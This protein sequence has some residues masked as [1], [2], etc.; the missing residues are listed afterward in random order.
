MR[1]AHD[2]GR[3]P[4]PFSVKPMFSFF[5]RKKPGPDPEAVPVSAEIPD[6]APVAPTELPLELQVARPVDDVPIGVETQ[7]P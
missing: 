7:A 4:E 3:W 1:L 2:V 5:K 6:V